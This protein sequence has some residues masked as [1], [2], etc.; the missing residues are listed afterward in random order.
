MLHYYAFPGAGSKQSAEERARA[1]GL[2]HSLAAAQVL[3]SSPCHYCYQLLLLLLP[4]LL[5]LLNILSI[6]V[7]AVVIVIMIIVLLLLFLEL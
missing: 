1:E 5:F 3:A 6:I 2:Q 4:L 7:V